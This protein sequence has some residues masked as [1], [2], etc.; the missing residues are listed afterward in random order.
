MGVARYIINPD[1][2]SCEFAIV[3]SDKVQ[4]QGIGTRLMKAL[5]DAAR[6]RGLTQI[7]G[8]VLRENEP[9]LKLMEELGFSI[10]QAPDERDIMEVEREL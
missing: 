7:E 3:I 5:M 10:A 4:Q 2:R 9:M 8:T 6:D 1:R